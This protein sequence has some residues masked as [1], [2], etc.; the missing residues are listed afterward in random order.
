[1]AFQYSTGFKNAVL[2]TGSLKSEFENM[3][4]K[5]YGDSIPAT[6]DAAET[7]TLLCTITG[8]V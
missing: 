6:A 2:D 8:P 7:G 5:L 4:I 1:M 3:V